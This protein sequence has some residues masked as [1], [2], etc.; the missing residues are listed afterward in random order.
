MEEKKCQ[1]VVVRYVPDEIRQEFV[2]IG[3]IMIDMESEK[4]YYKVCH[5]FKELR[6]RTVSV[7]VSLIKEFLSFLERSK[8]F[9]LKF[10]GEISKFFSHQIQFS[11]V[12]GSLYNNPEEELEKLYTRFVSLGEKPTVKRR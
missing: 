2:N 9:K 7:N 12:M 11:E 8:F 4:M 5:N 1:Y 10:L 6:K 3:I